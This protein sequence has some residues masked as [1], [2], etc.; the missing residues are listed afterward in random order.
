TGSATRTPT[1]TPTRTA[2][3]TPTPSATA[4]WTATAVPSGSPSA[5]IVGGCQVF[6]PDNPWNRDV[7]G[8]PVDTNS[9]TYVANIS[10]N[11]TYLHA[12][13]GSPAEYGIP[14]I[15]VPATQAMVPISFTDYGDE[16]DPGPYPVPANAP[17]EAGSDHHVLVLNAGTCMLYEMFNAG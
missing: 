2:T 9:D 14:Y 7:S 11:A 10:L 8:D 1:R 17:V 4:T 6:P 13:F 3:R 15:V 16:S 5:P 12:D